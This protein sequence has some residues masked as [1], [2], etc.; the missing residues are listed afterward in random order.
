MDSF[1]NNNNLL[2]GMDVV[3]SH[4]PKETWPIAA[5]VVSFG[6]TLAVSTWTQL[7]LL[8]VSTGTRPRIIPSSLGAASVC[9]ASI[10]SHH[11]AIVAHGQMETY[12]KRRRI[13][14]VPSIMNHLPDG[15]RQRLEEA[16]SGWNQSY[17]S[18]SKGECIDFFGFVRVPMHTVRVCILGLLAFKLLGGRFWAIAPSSYTNLGSFAR[19]G[20]P[21]TEKYANVAQKATL[22]RWG[23]QWGCHTCG[24][25]MGRSKFVGDHMP[26]KSVAEEWNARW[27]NRMLGRR[28]GFRFFPQCE[29][30]SR[31]QG[32]LL[33]KA[34]QQ[35]QGG[36]AKAGGGRL[37][38]NHSLRPR[39]NHLG[40]GVVAGVTVVGASD[41]DIQT[42]NTPRFR[43]MEDKARY[44][45]Y[46]MC[47]LINHK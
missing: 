32:S 4:C 45:L 18:L 43:D 13:S 26:P 12:K 17:K 14:T 27:H 37:A 16:S 28:V 7:A 25:R 22:Q 10:A 9:L 42:G 46:R 19:R 30:C 34:V 31:K 35:Q 23:K 38:Y 15:P 6:S 33:S 3:V 20:I 41:Q 29:P 39:W 1:W 5:G 11:M 8:G 47:W 44:L 24:T 2:P 36:L 40:G 21:A